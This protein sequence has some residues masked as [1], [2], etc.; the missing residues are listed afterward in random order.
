[1]CSSDL[2][3]NYLNKIWNSARFILSYLPDDFKPQ[4]LLREHLDPLQIGILHRFNELLAQVKTNLL[5]YEIGFASSLIYQFVYD[6][7]CSWY[8]EFSKLTLNQPEETKKTITLNVLYHLLKSIL[9]VL[10]PFAPFISE[11]IYLQL[12]GHLASIYLELYPSPLVLGNVDESYGLL[13]AMITDIRS[14]KVNHQ[15]AP[16]ANLKIAIHTNHPAVLQAILPYVERF[17]FSTVIAARATDTNLTS[18]TSYLY[19]QGKMYVEQVIDLLKLKT[20]LTATI[21]HLTVE[22][23]RAQGML[24]NPRFIEKAPQEKIKEEQEKLVLFEKQLLEAKEKL[25][26]IG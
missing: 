7:F 11:S 23:K 5:K 16:N 1:V 22:I 10:H 21:A 19:P 17:S 3:A 6:E 13:Q 15:L 26:Q 14:F 12:P 4:R 24:A 25:K 20:Q 9:I 18:M 2:Q 8:L